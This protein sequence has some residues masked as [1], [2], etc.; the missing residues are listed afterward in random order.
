M[1]AVEQNKRYR[2]RLINTGAFATFQFS[3]DN[4]SLSVIEADGTVVHPI[5]VHRLEIAVAQRYS[6]VLHANQTASNYWM[7]SQMNAFCFAVDNAVLDTDVRALLTYTNTTDPPTVSVDWADALDVECH[8]LNVTTLLPTAVSPAPPADTIY[9]VAFSFEIGGYQLDRAYINGSSWI[10][11]NVPTLNQAVKGLHENNSTFSTAGVSSAF[12]ANQYVIDVPSATVVDL[13][14]TNF[15]D[16]SH[17]FHL[18]GHHFWIIASSPDQYFDWST[19]HALNTTMPN[20]MHRDTLMIDAY[21]WALI[22]FEATNPGL[23][24]FHCHISWHIEAGLLMQFQTRDDIMRT[25][26]LPSDVLALCK[27]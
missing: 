2:Y 22:R 10:M 1:F 11:S 21:G 15:D 27:A 17:P 16:G 6:V 7:R 4:H 24:A 5:S 25:W 18:H 26:T 12:T 20:R 19:Y 9:A 13:L 8:D 3:V 23:W 14:V